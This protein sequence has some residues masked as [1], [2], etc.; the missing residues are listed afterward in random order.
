MKKE[1]D[2][3]TILGIGAS[4]LMVLFFV[5]VFYASSPRL[6]DLKDF[7]PARVP[8][9]TSD[10]LAQQIPFLKKVNALP[11]NIDP[12]ELGKENPYQ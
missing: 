2:L 5:W 12:A 10:G 4:V 11:I 1:L 9:I 3:I 7:L 6:S 8:S